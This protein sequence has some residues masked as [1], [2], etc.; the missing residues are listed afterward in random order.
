MT[1]LRSPDYPGVGEPARRRL[2]KGLAGGG[3]LVWAWNLANAAVGACRSGAA[4][5]A[6]GH[7]FQAGRWRD[8]GKALRRNNL[9]RLR[10]TFVRLQGAQRGA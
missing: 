4:R 7:R 5:R 2:V 6:G 3:A 10:R 8:A 9:R 1:D